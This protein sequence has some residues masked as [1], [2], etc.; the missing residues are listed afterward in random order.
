[1][2]IENETV[3]MLGTKKYAADVYIADVPK[4]V[5]EELL[6]DMKKELIEKGALCKVSIAQ[7]ETDQF[8]VMLFVMK[9]PRKDMASA[10]DAL[11][12]EI[13]RLEAIIAGGWWEVKADND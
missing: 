7:K 13:L 9:V 2:A 11:S 5:L 3:E 8:H 12:K 1:M 4:N 10:F 6:E